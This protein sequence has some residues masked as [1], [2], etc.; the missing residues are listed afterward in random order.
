MYFLLHLC[1]WHSKHLATIGYINEWVKA[2]PLLQF[3]L[4]KHLFLL[5][6]QEL[7]CMVGQ[8]VYCT[9]V[10]GGG[11]MLGL[12]S[13]L[14]STWK[15]SPEERAVYCISSKVLGDWWQCYDSPHSDFSCLIGYMPCCLLSTLP[16]SGVEDLLWVL[17]T[18]FQGAW[19]LFGETH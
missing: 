2:L 11:S 15:A 9:R 3:P 17:D 5:P 16:K 10:S 1:T 12:K 8:V 7:L 18:I 4:T 6:W 14:L 19:W 13:S